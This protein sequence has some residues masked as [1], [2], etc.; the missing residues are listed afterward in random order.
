MVQFISV[1]VL[2]V[3]IGSGCATTKGIDTISTHP[4]ISSEENDI[5]SN[6]CILGYSN[7]KE[8]DLLKLIRYINNGNRIVNDMC[9]MMEE[10]VSFFKGSDKPNCRYNASFILDRKVQLFDVGE[11]VRSFF[12]KRK[13]D[14]CRESHMDCGELTIILKLVDLVNSIV[15]ISLKTNNLDDLFKNIDAISFYELYQ[16]YSES[17]KNPQILANITLR[18]ERANSILERERMRIHHENTKS[19]TESILEYT[20]IYIGSP[21]KSGLLYIGDTLGSTVGTLFGSALSGTGEAISISGENK[22]ILVG[23]FSLIFIRR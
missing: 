22:L 15:F 20:S 19:S 11:N 14:A 2:A 23:L 13:Q 8:N 1:V 6:N 17:L 4:I 18:R 16:T 3:S 9:E 21:I 7:V 12:L 10:K 5:Y